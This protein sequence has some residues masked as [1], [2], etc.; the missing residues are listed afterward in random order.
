MRPEYLERLKADQVADNILGLKPRT[1][2]VRLPGVIV[3]LLGVFA[4]AENDTGGGL[5]REGIM[6]VIDDRL[7]DETYMAQLSNCEKARPQIALDGQIESLDNILSTIKNYR[8]IL[9]MLP[10]DDNTP[11]ANP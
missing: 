6:R 8:Q 9:N 7:G 4:E 1:L 10:P 3:E 11:D 5:L 2:T